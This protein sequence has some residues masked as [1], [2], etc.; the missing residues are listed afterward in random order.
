MDPFLELLAILAAI[1]AIE[2]CAWLRCGSVVLRERFVRW[3]RLASV[4]EFLQNG[5]AGVCVL[6]PLPC[7]VAPGAHRFAL[8]VS[9]RAVYAYS[10]QAFTATGRPPQS[11]IYVE[12]DELPNVRAAHGRLQIGDRVA[13]D[14]GSPSLALRYARL[15]RTLGAHREED[16]A[17]IIARD[18]HTSL[19]ARR[20]R[21]R[22]QRFRF[23]LLPL[24][25]LAT[26]LFLIV[27]AV[28]PAVHY[29]TTIVPH[30]KVL[31]TV[32]LYVHVLTVWCAYSL[33]RRTYPRH[34][35]ERR[36]KVGLMAFAPTY[37]MR[38]PQAVAADLLATFHPLAVAAV[39]LDEAQFRTF[40]RRVL[41]DARSPIDPVCGDER[42][43]VRETE[44]SF[45]AAALTAIEAMLVEHG[46]DPDA[47]LVAPERGDAECVAYCP[48]CE[49]QFATTEVRCEECGGKDLVPF[50]TPVANSTGSRDRRPA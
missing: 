18:L 29:T 13:A 10:F 49:E 7:D 39:F 48:R 28:L 9:P 23:G 15:L 40:A 50:D 47:L 35:S 31:L 45:R 8:S 11:E 19:D 5:R 25:C 22:W 16:R 3:S 17:A 34:R 6:S 21:R 14:L 26:A 4:L 2:C 37:T 38:A 12:I 27:F 42:H 36:G 44:A 41:R 1:Y 33:H 32:Y 24:R 46:V 43:A 20:V 30:W